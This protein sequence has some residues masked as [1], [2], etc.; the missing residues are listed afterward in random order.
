MT[1]RVLKESDVSVAGGSLYFG[2]RTS[3]GVDESWVGAVTDA[4]SRWR[5]FEV[6]LHDRGLDWAL[7]YAPADLR[8]ARSTRHRFGTQV[9]HLLPADYLEFVASVGYPVIGFSYYD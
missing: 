3:G 8:W 6:L 7:H 4:V 1:A 2:R 9:D 5:E